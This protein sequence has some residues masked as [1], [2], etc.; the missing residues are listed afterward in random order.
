MLRILFLAESP[1]DVTAEASNQEKGELLVASAE[2]FEVD[3]YLLEEGASL[4]VIQLPPDEMTDE[5]NINND[6][7]GKMPPACNKYEA[8]ARI[9]DKMESGINATQSSCGKDLVA[10]PIEEDLQ[11]QHSDSTQSTTSGTA[12]IG[13]RPL[14]AEFLSANV[15]RESRQTPMGLDLFTKD[16]EV[17][18]SKIEPGTLAENT[19]FC[20]GDRLL[21][22]NNKRCYIMDGKEV[23]EFID[24][25][26]GNVTIVV[27][28][29]GGDPNSVESMV[30]RPGKHKCG[31]AMKSAGRRNLRIT[32]IEKQGLFFESL[33]NV[34]DPIVSINGED[35]TACD[36]Y[37]AGE[38]IDRAG[39][40]ITVKAR[41]LF[42]TGVVVAAFSCTNS[43]GST[44]PP[45]LIQT[46]DQSRERMASRTQIFFTM[47]MVLILVGVVMAVGYFS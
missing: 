36:A 39:E 18:I 11:S 33:L 38:M 42:E 43:T 17:L 20:V 31:L 44:I 2:E 19:P 37:D 27:H 5:V 8:E 1:P 41:T 4:P 10:N 32:K 13:Q 23:M 3:G 45:E 24:N 30:T 14:R 6:D 47:A 22:V 21:S 28:N 25:L 9:I 26:I 35:C 16:G 12:A 7:D 34:G 46:L 29:Q 15:I 40:F